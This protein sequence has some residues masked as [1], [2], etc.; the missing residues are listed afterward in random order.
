MFAFPNKIQL[1]RLPT[2][3]EPLRNLSR[4]WGVDLRVKRDDLTG[5]ELTGNK[6]RK[7]EYLLAEA[8][9]RDCDTVVTCGAVTSN[10]ARA[11]SIAARR[12][13]LDTHLI[14]A[15]DLPAV[16]DGNLQLELLVGAA[17]RYISRKEYALDIDRILHETAD[18][19]KHEEKNP[20]IIPTGGSNATGLI[21]YVEAVREMR[22][23]CT[24]DHWQPDFLA[25][26]VGSGGTYAGLF[27]GNELFPLAETVLGVLVCATAD[28][29]TQKIIADV[30]TAA[31]LYHWDVPLEERKIRLAEG[32]IAGGYAQTNSDQLR[33]IRHVAQQEAI[34]LD[35]V[36]TGKALFGVYREIEAGRIPKGSKIL[37][38]HTGGIY[39]LSAYA[40]EMT[41]EWGSVEQ[42]GDEQKE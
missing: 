22:D 40:E 32:Y 39:G 10:H 23:Q 16:A 4:E 26:A 29:F 21:G 8:L 25:C 7:L 33:F 41:R 3:L 9:D 1:A 36:Y 27:L 5:T 31:Q 19:L 6:I 38:I 42:W 37:F 28:Y 24:H 12:L 17:V 35:P 30:R 20:Y 11:T 15:G 18:E 34:I 2:P 13:G 14:L